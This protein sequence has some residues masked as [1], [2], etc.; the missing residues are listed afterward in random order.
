M[1]SHESQPKAAHYRSG[2]PDGPALILSGSLGTTAE[3]WQSQLRALEAEHLVIRYDHRG[4][5]A[6]PAPD[7]PYSLADLAMDVIDILDFYSV[8]RVDFAG[9]SLG[10]MVGMWLAQHAPARVGRLAL[11]CTYAEAASPQMWG[12]RARSVRQLGTDS[13]IASSTERWFTESFR[14][15]NQT[16]VDEYAFDLAEVA[17]EGYAGCCEAIQ[18][19]DIASGLSQIA[20]PTLVI[21]GTYDVA[22]SPETMRSLA[23]SIPDALYAEVEA[24]H[25]ANVEKPEAVSELLVRHFG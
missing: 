20:V 21:A 8:D 23:G 16:L 24:A 11:L 18:T 2:N 7:G 4:H 3:M 14:R 5:G 10:G 12:E 15:E 9:L 1:S 6:S 25:L 17:D 22:A 13:V 19:M